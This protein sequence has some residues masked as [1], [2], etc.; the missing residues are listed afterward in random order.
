MENNLGATKNDL[1]QNLL[2]YAGLSNHSSSKLSAFGEGLEEKSTSGTKTA[3]TIENNLELMSTNLD[4][5]D[6]FDSHLKMKA[7]VTPDKFESFTDTKI[8]S[9]NSD[10]KYQYELYSD[11]SPKS[12]NLASRRLKW[13]SRQHSEVPKDAPRFSSQLLDHLLHETQLGDRPEPTE[14]RFSEILDPIDEENY[15]QDIH[16]LDDFSTANEA[17]NSISA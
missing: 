5:N 8:F 17:P 1:A 13:P 14:Q 9:K 10:T 11:S 7:C 6:G 12:S 15:I 16:G 2:G 3:K 4:T